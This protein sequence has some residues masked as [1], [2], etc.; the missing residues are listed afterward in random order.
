VARRCL[1]VQGRMSSL[2]IS[3]HPLWADFMPE[4]FDTLTSLQRFEASANAKDLVKAVLSIL[5]NNPAP[6]DVVIVSTWV[7]CHFKGLWV[8]VD[9]ESNAFRGVFRSIDA[10]KSA[11]GPLAIPEGFVLLF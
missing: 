11:M 2:A 10:A 6:Q 5:D 3:E 1:K 7:V 9:R 4:L 8:A